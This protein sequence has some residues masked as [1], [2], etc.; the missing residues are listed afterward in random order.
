MSRRRKVDPLPCISCGADYYGGC[1]NTDC[2]L[3]PGNC[4]SC[5]T[6]GGVRF[7][8]TCTYDRCADNGGPI[9]YS[10]GGS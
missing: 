6:C 1:A 2:A 9:D 7:K 8:G 5:P 4:T 3:Y 10:G